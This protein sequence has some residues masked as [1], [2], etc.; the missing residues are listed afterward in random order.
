MNKISQPSYVFCCISIGLS[1][2]QVIQPY[3]PLTQCCSVQQ[4]IELIQEEVDS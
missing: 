2:C 1:G 4:Q 3:Q